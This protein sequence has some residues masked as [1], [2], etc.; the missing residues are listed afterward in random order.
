MEHKIYY[1]IGKHSKQ[2][3]AEKMQISMVTLYRRL[4]DHK[5]KDADK[6]MIDKLYEE[7]AK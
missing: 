3:F 2:W 4:A 5:W 6:L 7:E 1:L